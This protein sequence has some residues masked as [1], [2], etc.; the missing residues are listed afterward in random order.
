MRGLTEERKIDAERLREEGEL[1]GVGGDRLLHEVGS[2]VA[3]VALEADNIA[4]RRS[5]PE[6]ACG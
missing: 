3:G 5:C 4:R 1:V 6:G 2:A